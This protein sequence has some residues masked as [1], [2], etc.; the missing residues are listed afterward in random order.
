MGYG[1]GKENLQL[2]KNLPKAQSSALIQMRTT[3]I[4][5]YKCLFTINRQESPW[6]EYRT[7]NQTVHHIIEDCSD[8]RDLRKEHF[9]SATLRD[10][11]LVLGTPTEA[12]K[13]SLYIIDSG[14]LD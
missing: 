3:K 4:G 14:L 9:G 8:F 1:P 5:L 11:R 2:Y 6:Y 12:A 13:A 7:A 10:A